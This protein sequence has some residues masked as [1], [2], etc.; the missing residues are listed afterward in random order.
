MLCRH[1]LL[2]LTCMFYVATYHASDISAAD[3]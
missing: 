3:Y 2:T 1:I